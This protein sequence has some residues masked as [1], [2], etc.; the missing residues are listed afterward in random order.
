MSDKPFYTEDAINAAIEHFRSQNADLLREG[1]GAAVM[2]RIGALVLP[3]VI[4]ALVAE[5]NN[6]SKPS[7]VQVAFAHVLASAICTVSNANYE[8]EKEHDGAHHMVELID[9][10]V[11]AMYDEHNAVGRLNLKPTPM[12]GGKH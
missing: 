7:D 2:A 11:C 12:A 8:A 6:D 3:S 9:P 4:R 10:L 5:I 1:G